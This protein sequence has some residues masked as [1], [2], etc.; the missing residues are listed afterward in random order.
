M[1][2]VIAVVAV[3]ALGFGMGRVKHPSNLKLANVKAEVVKLE[4]EAMVKE[5]AIKAEVLAVV[6]RVKAL[7]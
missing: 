3:L 5:A 4:A 7:L 2:H 1:V 6:A